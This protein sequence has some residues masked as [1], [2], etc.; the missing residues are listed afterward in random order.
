MTSNN[1][2][3]RLAKSMPT[4][5]HVFPFYGTAPPTQ[6]LSSWM[7]GI[8]LKDEIPWLM[9]STYLVCR[10]HFCVALGDN[11]FTTDVNINSVKVIIVLRRVL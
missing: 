1:T 5:E 2:T 10:E 8:Y 3:H 4:L 7:T 11:G 6:T 9:T